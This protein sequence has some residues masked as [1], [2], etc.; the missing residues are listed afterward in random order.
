M[1]DRQ[2]CLWQQLLKSWFKKKS[3]DVRNHLYDLFIQYV[4]KN[5]EYINTST[6]SDSENMEYHIVETMLK[7]FDVCLI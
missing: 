6:R 7:I 2:Q 1:I 5:L 3:A 4:T